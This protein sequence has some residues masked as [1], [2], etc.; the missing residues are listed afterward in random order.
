MGRIGLIALAVSLAANVFLGGFVAGRLLGL[1]DTEKSGELS[2]TRFTKRDV[3]GDP[4]EMSPAAREAF[5]KAYLDRRGEL[6]QGRQE[7]RMA[8][9]AFLESV[10]AAE[11]DRAAVEMALADIMTIERKRET[12]RSALLVDALENM[13]VEERRAWVARSAD[14]FSDGRFRDRYRRGRDDARKLRDTP[15]DAPSPDE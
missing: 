1:S 15:Q 3:P 11:W 10:S 2:T 8:R 14:R 4:R 13:P 9:R 7:S 5:R 12:A 6:A